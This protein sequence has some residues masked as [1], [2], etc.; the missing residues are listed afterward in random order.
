[1]AGVSKVILVGNLGRDPETRYT[2]NGT[3]N[4]QFTMAVS[5]RWTDQGGQQQERTTWFRITAWARLAETLDSLTQNGALAKGK[6]VYVMGNLEAREY[7]DQQGQTRTSLDVRAD[8]VQLLGSRA[9]AEGGMGG[10]GGSGGRGGRPGGDAEGFGA[11][12]ID[13]VPF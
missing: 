10:P 2:P 13:D 12:D 7:Q 11:G 5:R 4:V 8:E 3:M 9:D 1:M 6:Q